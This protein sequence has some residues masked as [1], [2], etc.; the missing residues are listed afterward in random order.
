MIVVIH[1]NDFTNK[2]KRIKK[3]NVIIVIL[4]KKLIEN[5][6][7]GWYE[8]PTR[9]QATNNRTSNGAGIDSDS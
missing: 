4:T 8:A 5:K 2:E 6:S 3:E 7:K 9:S 1:K